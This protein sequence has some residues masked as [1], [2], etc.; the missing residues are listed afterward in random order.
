MTTDVV[1]PIR[2]Q[3]VR[4]RVVHGRLRCPRCATM[5]L[6]DYDEYMCIDCGYEWEPAGEWYADLGEHHA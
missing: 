6:K 2:I 4:P 3:V 5:L 1:S